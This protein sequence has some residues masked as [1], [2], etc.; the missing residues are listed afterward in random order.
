MALVNRFGALRVSQLEALCHG[1]L[2][3]RSIYWNLEALIA[4]GLVDY[5]AT[6]GRQHTG[7][8][9]TVQGL[10]MYLGEDQPVTKSPRLCDI[11]H[12]LVCAETLIELCHRNNIEKIETEYEMSTKA[13]DGVLFDRMPD[14]MVT[15]RQGKYA[16]KIAVEV[17]TSQ[18]NKTRVEDII[19]NYRKSFEA[20][21]SCA[22][23]IIVACGLGIHKAYV[24]AIAQL[25]EDLQKKF[26]LFRSTQ[27]IGL[28]D[29][30]FGIRSAYIGRALQMNFTPCKGE[31][32]ETPVI[33][34]HNQLSQSVRSPVRH[35]D[36][37]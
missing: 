29:S 21:L 27:L 12:T 13:L 2:K 4:D 23:V 31:I 10:K 3:K 24:A 20:K 16:Y 28:K 26:V 7:Y 19:F 17:E 18:K 32:Y 37:V 30:A 25:P 1:R 33:S 22:G 36:E 6:A 14:A 34:G 11:N 15:L 8:M 35:G 9:G 5:F